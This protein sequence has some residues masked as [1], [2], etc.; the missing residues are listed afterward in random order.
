VFSKGNIYRGNKASHSNYGFWL[1]FSSDCVIRDNQIHNNRQA[2]IA[3]ENGIHFEVLENDIQNNAH[4]ILLWTRFYEFLKNVPEINATSR[5]WLIERNK[6]I[7]N[8]KA[9]R[10]AANQNHGVSPL[11]TEKSP[12][13][14]TDHKI[15]NNEIQEN[16]IGI[17]L[18]NVRD[19]QMSANNLHNL[20]TDVDEKPSS[21]M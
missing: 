3:V 4:G 1:G 19:T 6:L 17:E 10:I 14:P 16:N 18:E 21:A 8:R 20:M 9:I 7:R 12:L 15:Q 13:L 11:D 5:D 2:G